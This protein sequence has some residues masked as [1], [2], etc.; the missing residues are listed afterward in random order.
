M[1]IVIGIFVSIVVVLGAVLL[2]GRLRPV[3]HESVPQE[4]IP[5]PGAQAIPPTGSR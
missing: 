2:V 3:K 1:G 5:R 4:H